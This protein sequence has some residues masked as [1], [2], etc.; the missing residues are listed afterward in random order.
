MSGAPFV[1][2]DV[3]ETED[4]P[5]S[6]QH[7]KGDEKFESEHIDGRA[8]DL[9]VAFEKFK[10]RQINAENV[11]RQ[12]GGV[13]GGRAHILIIDFSDYLTRKRRKGYGANAYCLEL[14]RA[15]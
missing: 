4:L 13:C 15:R 2:E 1:K 7:I 12:T 6:D 14:V 11:G 3:Y 5:E 9:N 10:N 8:N